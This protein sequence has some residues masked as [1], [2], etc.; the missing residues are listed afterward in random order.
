M[1][2]FSCR[3]W[4]AGAYLFG[5]ALFRRKMSSEEMSFISPYFTGLIL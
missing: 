5:Q 2:S 1:L 3:A 4:M